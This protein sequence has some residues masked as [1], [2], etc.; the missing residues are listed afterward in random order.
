[1]ICF[2]PED[3][4]TS[5]LETEGF[6]VHPLRNLSR[7]GTNPLQDIRLIRE[8]SALYKIHGI[9]LVIHF[10]IKPNIYGCIAA[11]RAGVPSIAVVTGLGYTF[12]SR[13]IAS[14]MAQRLY[15]YAF[16][17][18][19][20]TIF[21][22]PDD[23]ALFIRQKLAAEDRSTV[24]LGSGIDTDFYAPITPVPVA[25]VFVFIGR[26]LHDKGIR[27][28]LEGFTYYSEKYPKA[29]LIIVGEPDPHNPA[30]VSETE[31]RKYRQQDAIEFAGF[32][33]DIRPYIQ[34]AS[35]VVLPS[36][37]EGVPRT[38]LEALSMGRPVIATDVPGCREVVVP[39]ENGL[40]IP[41]HNDRALAE[42][43]EEFHLLDDSV[44]QQMGRKSRELA[45]DIFSTQV[46][47]KAYL[48]WV[49]KVLNDR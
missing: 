34:R 6:E 31:L 20:L 26:L 29:R 28:L 2:A 7:K 38:L 24:V 25:P 15:R 46:V 33:S 9:N 35:A 14:K 10:T 23:R 11:H 18:N 8:L 3:E 39:H 21:Q 49:E 42:A 13:G 36:Y 5:Q 45:E 30:S 44:K 16:R 40:M 48:K 37:R 41:S 17:R 12:L 47:N 4:S 32:Q 43:F 1:M 27:E 19:Q 22:N